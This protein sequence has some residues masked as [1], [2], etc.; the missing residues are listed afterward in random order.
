MWRHCT[1]RLIEMIHIHTWKDVGI[2]THAHIERSRY[3]TLHWDGIVQCIYT[4]RP[5][6]QLHV[7]LQIFVLNRGR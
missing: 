1:P 6:R 4:N 3:C 5:E 2:D 7:C